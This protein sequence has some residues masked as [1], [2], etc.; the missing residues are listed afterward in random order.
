V[1]IPEYIKFPSARLKGCIILIMENSR[2]RRTPTPENEYKHEQDCECVRCI[3]IEIN[4]FNPRRL[5]RIPKRLPRPINN[6][7]K[8]KDEIY[9][10]NIKLEQKELNQLPI[11]RDYF[12]KD[13]E[14]EM[15][16]YFRTLKRKDQQLKELKQEIKNLQD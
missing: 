4:Q 9:N 3:D 7:Q 14:E 10:I 6:R 11:Y 5:P 1:K 13:I 2:I 15:D 12:Y 8:E 16:D